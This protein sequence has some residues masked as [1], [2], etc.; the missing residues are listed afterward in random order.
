MG[1]ATEAAVDERHAGQNAEP[2]FN[3]VEPATV[4]GSEDE[5]D[6]WVA[7]Q[8]SLGGRACPGTDVV[9]DQN[10][11]ASE[12]APNELVEKL[13][14]VGLGPVRRHPD[15]HLTG[16]DV[17]GSEPRYVGPATRR[18]D[19]YLDETFTRWKGAASGGRI[20][21]RI[22]RNVR[23]FTTHHGRSEYWPVPDHPWGCSIAA[24]NTG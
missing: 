12:V 16:L 24:H 22:G 2:D 19:A 21:P 3:L 11:P 23:H 1:D 6:P 7:G 20:C 9:G 10:Q 14:H 17:E 8:P 15:Q 4:L 18:T 13:Q 5:T